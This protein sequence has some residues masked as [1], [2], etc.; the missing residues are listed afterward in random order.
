MNFQID[1][2]FKK[3]KK[4]KPNGKIRGIDQ[5]KLLQFLVEKTRN[6]YI[7]RQML[8]HEII[9]INYYSRL[10][11]LINRQFKEIYDIYDTIINSE[12]ISTK[13]KERIKSLKAEI[14]NK[15]KK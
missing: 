11:R 10:S 14:K 1:F 3:I 4:C 5:V 12:F 2:Q 7:E 13:Q 8:Y 6:N 9:S 15:Q